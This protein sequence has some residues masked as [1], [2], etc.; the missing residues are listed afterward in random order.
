MKQGR[1]D[2]PRKNVPRDGYGYVS[3]YR[4]KLKAVE[5]D[6]FETP[7]LKNTL[8]QIKNGTKAANQLR[9]IEAKIRDNQTKR[10]YKA[11]AKAQGNKIA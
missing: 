2:D 9:A 3:P 10:A 11:R 4:A 1:K 8:S 7:A 5:R 6:Y